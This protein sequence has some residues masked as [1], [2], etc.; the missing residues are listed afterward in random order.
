M[1]AEQR[2]RELMEYC[3]GANWEDGVKAV[4]A[5]LAEARIEGLREA[6]GTLKILRQYLVSGKW[7][8]PNGVLNFI[9]AEIAALERGKGG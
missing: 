2:A 6:A 1:T 4:A 9:D 5:A 3:C 7:Q 8:Q